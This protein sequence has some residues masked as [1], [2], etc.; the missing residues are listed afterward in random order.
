M[1]VATL[2]FPVYTYLG[3][4]FHSILFSIVLFTALALLHSLSCLPSSACCLLP[5]QVQNSLKL[6]TLSLSLSESGIVLLIGKEEDEEIIF[7]LL[8]LILLLFCMR[9]TQQ[10][11]RKAEN[12]NFNEKW[13]HFL[14]IIVNYVKKLLVRR[15]KIIN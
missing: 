7:F 11:R 2:V 15:R 4:S 9:N 13:N 3:I 6:H 1:F 5:G 14:I 10:H 12:L 8:L